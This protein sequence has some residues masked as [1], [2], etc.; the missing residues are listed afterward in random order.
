MIE[1]W[2][3]ENRPDYQ[4]VLQ[5][6]EDAIERG[7]KRRQLEEEALQWQQEEERKALW[8]G[9]DSEAL[10]TDALEAQRRARE[11]VAFRELRNEIAKESG[12][13]AEWREVLNPLV[14]P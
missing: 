6:R 13:P 8:D 5:D 11:S 2:S 1:T 10:L 3:E 4:K 12:G 9:F 14:E 7:R